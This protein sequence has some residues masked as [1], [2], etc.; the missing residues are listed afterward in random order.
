MTRA[1][2]AGPHLPKGCPAAGEGR[3]LPGMPPRR[4]PQPPAPPGAGPP[5]LD[6]QAVPRAAL[7]AALEEVAHWLPA[8]GP[9]SVF[10]HHNTLHA[11]QHL[12]FDEACR[13]AA[14]VY[15]ADTY[16]AQPH[17]RNLYRQGRI[18]AEDL[19]A[20]TVDCSDA[21]L[22]QARAGIPALDRRS[23][24]RLLLLPGLRP[25]CAG[26]VDWHLE[27]GDWLKR[28]RRDL[29]AAHAERLRGHE[30][31]R[32]Y[33]VCLERN[34][35][36]IQPER[37]RPGRPADAVRW[38]H[39]IDLDA[40]IHPLLIAIAAAH[41]DQ[42]LAR[43]RPP[44]AD[45]GLW[46]SGVALLGARTFLAPRGLERLPQRL[47]EFAG[48]GADAALL[49]A[50]EALGIP[51]IEWA[52][53]L[54]AE[55]LALP[56]WTG[57][58]HR[59]EVEPGLA[60]YRQVQVRL[61]D[62]L[63]LRL[64]LTLAALDAFGWRRG[65]WCTVHSPA[66]D[67]QRNR[68]LAAARLFDLAQILGLPPEALE[69]LDPIEL[70]RLR[71]EVERHGDLSLRARWLTAYERRHEQR[72]LA[73]LALHLAHPPATASGRPSAQVIFCIDDR[74]ESLRRHLEEIDPGVQTCGAAGFFGVA[75]EFQGLDAA[76]GVALCPVV[77]RPRH[78]VHEDARAGDEH[79]FRRR[80][81]LRAHWSRLAR[82]TRIDSRGLLLGWLTTP[83]LGVLALAPLLAR[84]LGPAHYAGL[85]GRLREVVLP[86]P[87][88]QVQITRTEARG[89]D[90]DP[91]G[92]HAHDR[93]G[94]ELLA[95]FDVREKAAS[96][97]SVLKPARLTERHARLVL[98]VGHGADSRN[99]PH[100]SAYA[101]GAC[102]GRGGGPNARVFTR[103]ANDP[104][105]R[106][107][108]HGLGVHLA[109]DVVFVAAYHDTCA[110]TIEYFDQEDVPATHR[111]DLA[112]LSRTLED[113]LDRNAQERSRRFT[114]S[115]PPLDA[116]AARR[117]IRARAEHLAEPRP[118]YGHGTNA[119]CIV[120]PR[121]LTR[122]LFLDRRAFLV[123]Y[124]A[125]GDDDGSLLAQ[126]LSA[127]FPVCGG[128]SLEYY[129]STVD[130]ERFGCGTK[131]PHNLSGLVGVMNGCLGDLRTGLPL[132]TVELHE[133]M[134]M[135]FVI[136]STPDR[137]LA[138][139]RE[140]P[141][142][143]EF[144][145]NDW[146]R[147]VTLDPCTHAMQRWQGGHFVPFMAD[148]TTALPH[149]QDS[150]SWALGRSEH[151]PLARVQPA[152]FPPPA[153]LRL[154]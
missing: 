112:A 72:V 90:S 20:A 23:L 39:G 127:A 136:H 53:V 121:A 77:V 149:V 32:L 114:E 140:R 71:L 21:P 141:A 61:A 75:M 85:L 3:S 135:L 38:R 129:F 87:R 52:G 101:C 40:L 110:D 17:F 59:I 51:E 95:G 63:A 82:T 36:A 103:M 104:E 147:V 15:T 113:A 120:A 83:V 128:I 146:I 12:P 69:G 153:E 88:S 106:A 133:A 37:V 89:D 76:S 11:L 67:P 79:S 33:D 14:Q 125:D 41:L 73:P 68:R 26:N 5:P 144:M 116:R 84:L 142:L 86:R 9:I 130:N 50:L 62:F 19:E 35:F 78:R 91:T 131:L 94:R 2:E 105:V 138:V 25:V 118:E 74:E 148:G 7:A 107:E 29:P 96:V 99:N 64:L 4:Q 80:Q 27:E 66:E 54:R 139:L 31:R 151:L 115:P 56:G 132:Q 55:A 1:G 119:I 18:L 34:V 134:R 46:H 117:A 98:V 145:Q 97:A 60:P 42:G 81:R 70:E 143:A 16:L 150:L 24:L 48:L 57:M 92:S 44:D 100:L 6:G 124:D 13:L 102:G 28:W 8:Q 126:V 108:L 45:A 111:A 93:G 154:A 30:P 47:R 58:V 152:R 43:T 109:E 122:G 65:H 123:S 10:V 137:L 22:W 49:A